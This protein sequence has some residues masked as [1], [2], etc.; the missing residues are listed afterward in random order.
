MIK[1]PTTRKLSNKKL[2]AAID[3]EGNP[4]LKIFPDEEFYQIPRYPDIYISQYARIIH[5]YKDS[6][7][8]LM[9]PYYDANTGYTTITLM[10]KQKKRVC[11]G[12]HQLVALVW[13]EKP[14][15]RKSVV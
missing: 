2:S 1:I 5:T 12:L 3:R 11:Y 6:A 7:S 10:N 4:V 8:R 15:D 14:K 13:L 9:Y